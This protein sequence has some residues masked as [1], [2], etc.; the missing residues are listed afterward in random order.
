M[1]TTNKSTFRKPYFFYKSK[2]KRIYFQI[3]CKFCNRLVKE[4]G[5]KNKKYIKKAKQQTA[6]WVLSTW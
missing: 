5:N 4:K 1:S 3:N 2:F 6:N